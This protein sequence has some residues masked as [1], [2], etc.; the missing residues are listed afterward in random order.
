MFNEND[1]YHKAWSREQSNKLVAIVQ[2][3]EKRLNEHDVRMA[4]LEERQEATHASLQEV[5][6]ALNKVRDVLTKVENTVSVNS[7]RG[8]IMIKIIGT[9]LPLIAALEIWGRISP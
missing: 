5:S 1:P 4:R 3:L 9:L 6:G 7:D 2:G 8:S